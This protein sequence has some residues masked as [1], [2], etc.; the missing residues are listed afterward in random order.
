MRRRFL[1]PVF[2]LISGYL[3]ASVAAVLSLQDVCS[4][5][6][7]PVRLISMPYN[8]SP[9]SPAAG[10]SYNPSLSVT[11][12]LIVFESNAR[13][14]IPN[15]TNPANDVFL[16]YRDSCTIHLLSP[17]PGN[18]Q[19]NDWSSEGT[20]GS[21]FDAIAFTSRTSN[22][23]RQLL[24][25]GGAG[26]TTIAVG[27]GSVDKPGL[28]A[29]GRF[30][31][32]AYTPPLTDPSQINQRRDVVILNRQTGRREI[33]SV[34]MNNTAANGA[35]DFPSISADGRFV[36]FQSDATNLV[37]NDFNGETD[38]FLFD[39]E[40]WTMTIV[41]RGL[42]G[43]SGAGWSIGPAIS[44]NG[45]YVAFTSAAGNLV[46]GDTNNAS[47]VFVFDR[48]TLQISRVSVAKGAL[49]GNGNSDSASISLDGRFI[50]FRSVATNLV[51]GDTNDC[52]YTS[53]SRN[54]PDVFVHDRMLGST[55]R[56]SVAANGTQAE[57]ESGAPFISGDGRW[58]AYHSTAP[59]IT[60]NDGQSY[61]DVFLVDWMR[62]LG[63][64]V[65]L[66]APVPTERPPFYVNNFN[67]DF[68]QGMFGWS[69]WDAITYR[70]NN[71][72]FEFYRNPG[73][74][75]AVLLREAV[76]GGLSA[77]TAL[78]TYFELG[79]NST[80]R[81]RVVVLLHTNDFSESRTCAFWLPPSTPLRSYAMLTYFPT[82][83]PN[84]TVSFYASPADGQGWIE[85]DN[86]SME[87]GDYL[88]V[89]VPT[90]P[91]GRTQCFDPAAP[92]PLGAAAP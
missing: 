11:G 61:S 40:T 37:S 64:Q 76:P 89:P 83:W 58:V 31:V 18:Y 26:V 59:N 45:R 22:G 24:V 62:L 70:V 44:S 68:S 42:G 41:S 82:A 85:L 66:P 56:V 78:R 21:Q 13:N 60:L 63:V 25:T 3:L 81:K 50:A 54:C 73:S 87:T 65:P 53:P 30:V 17:D 74:V 57:G 10:G 48:E 20:I 71:G 75:S 72:V 47:D 23:E 16:R 4:S 69:V 80:V 1:L 15:D 29:D 14:L 28:S 36:A 90:Q 38:V 27:A 52:T 51:V 9:Y 6:T 12:N 34:G 32:Y 8:P 19:M 88:M 43:E 39:R 35:S 91:L 2:I 5:D 92:V 55:V 79:N 86:F 7:S 77:S 84:L 46:T 33:V 67:G 49:Q